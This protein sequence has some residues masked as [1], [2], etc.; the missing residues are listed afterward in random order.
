MSPRV[1]GLGLRSPDRER[2]SDVSLAG[3][4]IVHRIG[5]CHAASGEL[6][7]APPPPDPSSAQIQVLAGAMLCRLL[8]WTEEEWEQLPE[9]ARPLEFTHAPGLGWIGALPVAGLN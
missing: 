1:G 6:D 8:I 7:P 9:S 2:P 5:R 3:S 4:E